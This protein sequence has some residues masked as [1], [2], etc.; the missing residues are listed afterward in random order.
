MSL[1]KVLTK[2]DCGAKRNA[3]MSRDPWQPR[4]QQPPPINFTLRN[5][6]EILTNLFPHQCQ[7]RGREGR[8]ANCYAKARFGAQNN[9]TTSQTEYTLFEAWQKPTCEIR[10]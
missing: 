8:G 1:G 6:V 9:C 10:A 3:S 4:E 5:S 2:A 7:Q